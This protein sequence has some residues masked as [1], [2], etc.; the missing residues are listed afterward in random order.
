MDHC[1]FEKSSRNQHFQS[2]GTLL[3]GRE[4]SIP[5]RR[6]PYRRVPLGRVRL[7]ERQLDEVQ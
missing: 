7:D 1:D 6:E 2:T 4:E 5:Y 3:V